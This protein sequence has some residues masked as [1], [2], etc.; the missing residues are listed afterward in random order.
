MHNVFQVS[1]VSKYVPE[2]DHATI[3]EPIEV[4]ED[5]VYAEHPV[6]ILDHMIKQ[7]RNKQISQS[8]LG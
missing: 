7:L 2:P 5:H 8:P 1:Q 4:I 3:T 6:L